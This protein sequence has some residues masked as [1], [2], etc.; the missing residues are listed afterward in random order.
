MAEQ[1]WSRSL[2]LRAQSFVDDEGDD[3][4]QRLHK[5]IMAAIAGLTAIAGV[6]WGSMYLMLGGPPASVISPWI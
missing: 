2:V 1:P 4:D 6:I 5:R 3:A